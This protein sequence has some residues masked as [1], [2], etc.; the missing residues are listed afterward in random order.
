[1]SGSTGG[2][3]VPGVGAERTTYESEIMWGADQARNAALWKSQ[4]ISGTARDDANTNFTH[5]L[6]PGLILGKLDSTGELEEWD[7]DVATGTQNIAGVLD[8][9]LRATDFDAANADRVFRVLVARAPLKSR[10]LLIQGAA[11]IGHVDEYL[12]RMQ[13]HQAGMVLDDD[14]FGYKSG[15]VDRYA[16]VADTTDT[17]TEAE[18]GSTI[19]YSNAASVTVTLPAAKPGLRYEICRTGDEEFIF[20]SPTADNVIVG[21]DLSADGITV[22]TASEHLGVRW[23]LRSVYMGTTVKWLVEGPLTPLGTGTATPTYSIQTA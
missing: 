5:V 22:T 10:K 18:N 21:N 17:L 11:F 6:R 7:A 20:V 23:R 12:A 8:T 15:L 16:V 1:M 4:V 19:F 3:G 14:P 13:L 2:F 9:E